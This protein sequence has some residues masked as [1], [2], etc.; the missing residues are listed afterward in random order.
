MLLQ[1]VLPQPSQFASLLAGQGWR[2]S[3]ACTVFQCFCFSCACLRQ[4]QAAQHGF[5]WLSL[6]CLCVSGLQAPASITF[7]LSGSRFLPQPQ[8]TLSSLICRRPSSSLTC[9]PQSAQRSSATPR[10][11]PTSSTLMCSPPAPGRCY[12][13]T[14]RSS[15]C[16]TRMKMQGNVGWCPL[17]MP[18]LFKLAACQSRWL[19]RTHS[20]SICLHGQQCV[21]VLGQVHVF[22]VDSLHTTWGPRS[23][24]GCLK[25]P[26]TQPAHASLPST[27]A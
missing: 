22:L 24:W 11:S 20:S 14:Q 17:V 1:P 21:C 25:L 19:A 6:W 23:Q 8:G 9:S 15:F 27:R 12:P 16:Q 5:H 4:A 18:D 3:A 13:P 26:R 2:P 7:W 10:A